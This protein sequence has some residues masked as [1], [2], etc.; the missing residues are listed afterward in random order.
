MHGCSTDASVQHLHLIA[1][2]IAK[3]GL[4]FKK[5]ISKNNKVQNCHVYYSS[6]IV[7]KLV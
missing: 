4:A 2:N 3:L 1:L 6:T 5:V 7:E